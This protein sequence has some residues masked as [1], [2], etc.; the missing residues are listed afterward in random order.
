MGLQPSEVR[1]LTLPQFLLMQDAYVRAHAPP[2]KG[3]GTPP[4]P[5]PPDIAR[6][7]KARES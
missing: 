5:P 7:L 6:L 4:P 1:S 3:G 2:G